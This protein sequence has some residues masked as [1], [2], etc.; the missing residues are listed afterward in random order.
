MNY[1]EFHLW[2]KLLNCS[3]GQRRKLVFQW[4]KT[5][6]ITQKFFDKIC[7]ELLLGS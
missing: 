7:Q 2:K 3:V 6:V 1:D 5:G 4:V